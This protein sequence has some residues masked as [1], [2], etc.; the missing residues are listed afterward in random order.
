MAKYFSQEHRP[1]KR[2]RE[3]KGN[4]GA[5]DVFPQDKNQKEDDLSS[6]NVKK[7][8]QALPVFQDDTE[9]GSV[10]KGFAQSH[11]NHNNMSNHNVDTFGKKLKD[12][13]VGILTKKAD[14]NVISDKSDRKK[15]GRRLVSLKSS[16]L[17]VRVADQF[18]GRS[19][20]PSVMIR[21]EVCVRPVH[22]T[23]TDKA[24]DACTGH[25]RYRDRRSTGEGRWV[26]PRTA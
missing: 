4:W 8:F 6:D 7:G 2:K 9:Y 25:K 13:F 26:R 22:D 18:I 24:G 5:P 15:V 12:S 23:R 3:D 11:H 10:G 16:L 20:C 14:G 17:P 19:V 1:L 21:F